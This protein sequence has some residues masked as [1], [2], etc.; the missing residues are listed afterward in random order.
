MWLTIRTI[1]IFAAVAAY[2]LTVGFWI[3]L[4]GEIAGL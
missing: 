1:G 3:W 2:F 4:A